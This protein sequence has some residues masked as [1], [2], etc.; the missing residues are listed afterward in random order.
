MTLLTIREAAQLVGRTPAT[1]RRYIRSGRLAAAKETGKFGEEYR[2]RREDLLAL[3]F[4]PTAAETR[5]E[6]VLS[7][8]PPPASMESMVPAS[9]FNDLLMKHEQMLVQ[10]GMIRA[11]GQKLLEYKAEAEAKD[12]A[13]NRASEGYRALRARAVKEIRFLRKHLRQ[14]EIEVEDR[15]IEIVLL[16]EK[17][18]RLEKAAANAASIDSFDKKV[19]EIRQKERAIAQLQAADPAPPV[20]GPPGPWVESFPPG[21]RGEDN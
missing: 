8:A 7:A 6:L 4:A 15:N 18:K 16:Q 14:A 13:L 10:Y 20:Y 5:T 17:V 3:G 9:L 19:V 2:I 1:I 12:E 21:E 11:G